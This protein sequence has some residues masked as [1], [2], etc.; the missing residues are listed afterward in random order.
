[1]RI[2]LTL[3]KL[4]LCGCTFGEAGLLA[5][6]QA[7]VKQCSLKV[8]SLPEELSDTGAGNSIKTALSRLQVFFEPPE[9][10]DW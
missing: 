10:P 2:I 1:M 7:F 3:E 6:E 5:L 9:V 4:N 8:L